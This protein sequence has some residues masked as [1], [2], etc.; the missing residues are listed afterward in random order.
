MTS[1]M[2]FIKHDDPAISRLSADLLS[3]SHELSK[4]WKE[5][6]TYVET[7]EMRLKD[8]VCDSVLKFK[9]DKINKMRK[10]IMVL[11]EEA[12]GANDIERVIQLQ[13]RVSNL[14]TALG[15]I[16]KKLGNRIVL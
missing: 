6:Q 13:R 5:K 10:E 2:Q 3:D 15:E 9:S 1:D 11:M 16:S 14:N 4:I 12:V 8:I 7:E